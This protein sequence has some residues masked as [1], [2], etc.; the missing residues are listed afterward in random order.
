MVFPEQELYSSGILFRFEPDVFEIYER[1]KI[2]WK[3]HKSGTEKSC[4]MF[5]RNEIWIRIW[6]LTVKRSKNKVGKEISL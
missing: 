6:M 4:P 2:E 5:Y 1:K 3:I